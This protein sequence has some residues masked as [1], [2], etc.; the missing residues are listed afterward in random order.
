MKRIL[1]VGEDALCCALGKR[2]VEEVMPGWSLAGEP[3]NKRGITELVPALPR[4]LNQARYVQPVLCIADTDGR[5]VRDL[6]RKWLSS[7]EIRSCAFYLRLAVT[8]AESWVLADREKFAVHFGVSVTKIPHCTDEIDDPKR[9]ILSL[10]RKS[11]SRIHRVEM[12]SE[13]DA[14]KP[15]SG[16]NEHL[17]FF[18]KEV[19]RPLV[20]CSNS[21]SLA[22]AV[23][24]LRE[25]VGSMESIS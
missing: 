24:R 1:V 15:G 7:L 11:R 13:S 14:G 12:V 20:G 17:Q 10:V 21:E 5:C 18:V 19:W 6:L 2:L 25:F 4:Y 9:L 16:Y 3:I 8:E 23:R 22:R